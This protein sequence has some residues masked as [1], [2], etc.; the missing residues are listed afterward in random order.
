[1]VEDNDTCILWMSISNAIPITSIMI[2]DWI[3][4]RLKQRLRGFEW[5]I[6]MIT[7]TIFFVF[8]I[9]FSIWEEMPIS[10]YGNRIIII[11]SFKVVVT[12]KLIS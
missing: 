12:F 7:M 8:M 5:A 1:M 11:V 10:K 4:S 2:I 6:Q 3:V 9:W